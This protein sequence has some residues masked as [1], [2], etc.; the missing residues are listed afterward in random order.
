MARRNKIF[1]QQAPLRP[2]Y[3]FKA[4]LKELI[5]KLNKIKFN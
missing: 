3:K 4:E 1:C 5:N 2:N